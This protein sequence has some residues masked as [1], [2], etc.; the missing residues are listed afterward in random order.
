MLAALRTA[1]SPAL[2]A[3]IDAHRGRIDS[4]LGVAKLQRGDKGRGGDS[5]MSIPVRQAEVLNTLAAVDPTV[6][7]ADAY[8]RLPNSATRV[9]NALE[10]KGYVKESPNTAMVGFGG[11][12][13][14]AWQAERGGRDWRITAFGRGFLALA[15]GVP[16]PT[17]DAA[18]VAMLRSLVRHAR[19]KIAANTPLALPA[20]TAQLDTLLAYLAAWGV[21]YRNDA[22][23]LFAPWFATADGYRAAQ[24]INAELAAPTPAPTPPAPAA[25][26]TL[27]DALRPYVQNDEEADD[28]ADEARSALRKGVQDALTQAV[29]RLRVT[30]AGKQRES[31]GFE[32]PFYG[33]ERTTLY[34]AVTYPEYAIR[35]G[36][37]RLSLQKQ[38][39]AALSSVWHYFTE[40]T[41]LIDADRIA[42]FPALLLPIVQETLA[43]WEPEPETDADDLEE[44]M[45][46]TGAVEDDSKTEYT[47][48]RGDVT[49]AYE[50]ESAEFWFKF[51]PDRTP[52]PPTVTVAEDGDL[53]IRV[54]M[55]R[56]VKLSDVYSPWYRR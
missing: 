28:A 6:A 15:R 49:K 1:A 50:G 13:G 29:P 24:A 38:W 23:W 17:L 47:D 18:H 12:K 56:H 46:Q 36:T 53:L 32:S 26:R 37:V 33:R 40:R 5:L 48:S 10:A 3:W 45:W 8:V 52:T 4:I 21:L 51:E 55:R 54:V 30:F 35:Q 20:H 39:I 31:Y 34:G 9:A 11:G 22:G 44:R 27:A 42:Y 41:D 7:R 25:P 19:T 14:S 16:A 2:R 43:D